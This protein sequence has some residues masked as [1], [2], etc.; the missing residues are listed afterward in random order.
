[1]EKTKLEVGDLVYWTLDPLGFRGKR[2]PL[3]F[4]AGVFWIGIITK[5]AKKRK[6]IEVFWL[7]TDTFKVLNEDH[8]IL[9]AISDV[10]KGENN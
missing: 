7:N 6:G 8:L 3:T 2:N 1:M 4:E 9:A 5:R 10:N